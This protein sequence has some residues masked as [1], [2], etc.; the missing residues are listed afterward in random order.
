MSDKNKIIPHNKQNSHNTHHPEWYNNSQ[1][2][3]PHLAGKTHPRAFNK[4]RHNE[5]LKIIK[6]FRSRAPD[7]LNNQAEQ[8]STDG[9]IKTMSDA[10][11]TPPIF[12]SFPIPE[13]GRF[14]PY[15]SYLDNKGLLNADPRSIQQTEDVYIDSQFR[16]TEPDIEKSDSIHIQ[17]K[18]SLEF[19]NLSRTVTITH[20]G[21]TFDIEDKISVSGVKGISKKLLIKSIE[22]GVEKTVIEFTKDSENM[23]INIDHNLSDDYIDGYATVTIL[24]I[25]ANTNGTYIDSLPINL[26][27]KTHP[28][29][30]YRDSEGIPDNDNAFYVKLGRTYR[31]ED[32]GIFTPDQYTFTIIF[33]HVCGIPLKYLNADFPVSSS[34]T[35]GYHEIINVYESSYSFN[36][37]V[38]AYCKNITTG[39]G[40]AIQITTIKVISEGSTSANNYT[41]TL[42]RTYHQI[43]GARITSMVFPVTQKAF[44][45]K[46][47][48]LYWQNLDDGDHVYS[49]SIDPGNYFPEELI[50]ILH[51]KFYNTLRV[52]VDSDENNSFITSYT[53]HQFTQISIDASSDVVTFRSFRE[54]I[55]SQ[56]ITSTDPIIPEVVGNE[57]SEL[58][59]SN[60]KLIITHNNHNLEL[61][62][63]ILIQNAVAHMG[64]ASTY[65]N[66][67]HEIIEII[68]ANSYKIKL[69]RFNIQASRSNTGGGNAVY[70]Y[71]P[72]TF[73][74]RFDYPETMGKNLGFRNAG[75]SKSI[76]PYLTRVSNNEPYEDDVAKDVNG[77]DI[78][79]SNNSLSLSGNDYVIMTCR[80]L[81]NATSVGPIK[82]IFTKILLTDVP[83]KTIF[84][85]HLPITSVFVEPVA[86]ISELTFSFYNPDGTEYD[87][88][89]LDH[90]FN[91]ELITLRENPKDTGISA[92][93]GRPINYEI[94]NDVN[95]I[96]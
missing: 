51:N 52:N 72:N 90:S 9:I 86:E 49:I 46:N 23:K 64:I 12:N 34:Q 33:E 83:G 11:K 61:G 20:P 88:E 84:N 4:D 3:V 43:I 67:E 75:D 53:Q 66:G 92:K 22:D 94:I 41:I 37:A 60:I 50:D 36:L 13:E 81:N 57:S 31:K 74:L 32:D 28:I 65:I 62:D 93:T 10:K 91:L 16:I 55:L 24:G 21:H 35:Q 26:I 19:T 96:N 70:I 47:N 63:L 25:K 8:R 80:E 59:T 45:E 7:Y 27:N 77:K 73:R 58:L 85:T 69:N 79:I 87:T 56:P 14:D 82:E 5:Q 89:G 78:I 71:S 42:P 1:F 40:G 68:D 44:T 17:G 29:Y 6:D 95:K 30:L 15:L 18:S 54:S 2:I 76:T 38:P 48:K 39:G